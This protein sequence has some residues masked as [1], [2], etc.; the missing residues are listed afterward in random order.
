MHQ[1]YYASDWQVCSDKVLNRKRAK[2]R[3]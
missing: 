2:N 3:R 1:I